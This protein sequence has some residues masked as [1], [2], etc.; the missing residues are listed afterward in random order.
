MVKELR[1]TTGQVRRGD[2][3]IWVCSEEAKGDLIAVFGYLI[4]K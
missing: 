4:G 3:E 1:H 2:W